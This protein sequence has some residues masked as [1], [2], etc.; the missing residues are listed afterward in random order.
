MTGFKPLL[1]KEAD[2]SCLDYGNIWASPKLDGI[3]AIVING[4]V[5][6]RKLLPIP[7]PHVQAMF[8]HLE[9][10]DGEL[11][12]GEPH[13]KDV[14]SQ[15]YSGVMKSTGTPDVRL[16]VFDHI[17][18]PNAEY[19]HRYNAVKS[20]AAGADET[21]IVQQHPVNHHDDLLD[22]ETRYLSLG[23]EGLMLRAIQGPR[24]RYKFGRST[25]REGTLLKLKRFA[26]AEA[27]IVGFEE[28][29]ANNNEAVKD[30]LGNTKRSSHQEN[31]TGKGR[32]GALVCETGDGVRFNIGTGF[33]AQQRQEIWDERDDLLGTLVKYKCFPIGV[34]AAPRFPVFLGHR[35]T[36]DL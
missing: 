12:V 4:V 27:K 32:L 16:F 22:I 2:L 3:R 23:Y 8:G 21:P 24:S 15:T 18:D 31:K 17:G 20:L 33:T 19:H 6:S 36:L 28:E 34:K 5:L 26:D 1:A 30:E 25:T 13:A 10:L 11:I 29:M 14:Y 7:N 9:H 35:S